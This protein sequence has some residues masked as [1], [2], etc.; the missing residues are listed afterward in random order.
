MGRGDTAAQAPS[1]SDET[2]DRSAGEWW[3]FQLRS[4]HRFAT[5]D[6]L[7]AWTTRRARP[8]AR[9]LL[10]L[11]AGVGSIGLMA[12]LRMADDAP[13]TTIEVQPPAIALFT[14]A[15][16]GERTDLPRLTVRGPD[17]LRTA[18]YR[19]VRREMLIEA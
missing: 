6:V 16:Q 7:V 1:G 18:E 12:L 14:C 13:L 9:R 4:A 15:W 10:D 19:G 8:R 17:R 2:L 11:G 3:I 5:D